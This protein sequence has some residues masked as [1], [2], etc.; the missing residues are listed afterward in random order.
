MKDPNLLMPD[1]AAVFHPNPDQPNNSAPLHLSCYG[2][3]QAGRYEGIVWQK[4]RMF[5]GGH[6]SVMMMSRY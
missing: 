2:P 4:I 1:N 5:R 6:D 3:E